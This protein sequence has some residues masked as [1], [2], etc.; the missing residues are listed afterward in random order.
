MGKRA[1]KKLH[2]E[3]RAGSTGK[4]RAVLDTSS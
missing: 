3:A 2:I 1:S 4:E